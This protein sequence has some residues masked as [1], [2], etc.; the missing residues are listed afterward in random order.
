MSEFE[1]NKF[2]G[3]QA[4]Y[5]K[6]KGFLT[7]AEISVKLSHLQPV[8]RRKVIGALGI[9]TVV[10]SGLSLFSPDVFQPIIDR[11]CPSAPFNKMARDFICGR[12][13]PVNSHVIP[14]QR[15]PYAR[16]SR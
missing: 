9:P 6:D 11:N 3:A 13:S 10:V 7:R 5:F 14:K 2:L 15:R 12:Y 4:R 16:A 1:P 8:I